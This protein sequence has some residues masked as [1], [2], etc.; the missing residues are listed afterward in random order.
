MNG[1]NQKLSARRLGKQSTILGCI[2]LICILIFG[3]RAKAGFTLA[4][5]TVIY[6]LPGYNYAPSVFQNGN[7]AYFWWCGYNQPLNADSIYY[8]SINLTT[9]T[10]ITSPEIVMVPSASGWDKGNVCDPSVIQGSFYPPGLGG[11][12]AYA[13][14]YGAALNKTGTPQGAVGVAFSNNGINWTKYSGNPIITP[15]V[16]PTGN[17]YGAGQPSTYNSNGGSNVTVFY[18]DT[19]YGL[20][21][22]MRT[23]TDGVHFGNATQIS[24]AGLKSTAN[25]PDAD[26]GYD[27]NT[28]TWYAIFPDGP[29]RPG[30]PERWSM[31]L[32]E[33]P[34]GQSLSSG[35]W[36][37]LGTI[38]TNLTGNYLADNPGLL[39]DMYGN[40]TAFLP[41]VEVFYSRGGTDGYPYNSWQ[42]TFAV[43]NPSPSTLPF[44]RYYSAT[45]GDHWVTTGYYS[46]SYY[47]L[48]WTLGYLYMAPQSGT[49]AVYG[50]QIGNDHFVSTDSNCEGQFILGLNGYIYSSNVAGTQALYR[51]YTGTDHFVSQDPNCEGYRE[52]FRIGYAKTQP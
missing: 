31:T 45:Y 33:M 42:L 28:G 20:Y 48:E 9:Q 4:N 37:A 47:H 34:P 21:T 12:Y 49:Y 2:L 17:T 36:Q 38:D 44:N 40:V 22:Y 10:F 15:F 39:R 14:Y 32:Y 30:L 19:T 35:T 1:K 41:N 43:W 16:W 46:S 3:V 26:F 50:C 27:S 25:T 23:T 24:Q 51:C 6:R 29:N 7:V 13:M 5:G 11:P 8:A 18:T 52:E